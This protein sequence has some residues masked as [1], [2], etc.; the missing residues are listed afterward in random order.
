MNLERMLDEREI[1]QA[2]GRYARALDRRNWALLE[3]VFAADVQADYNGG[4]FLIEGRSA[5]VAMIRS[6]LDGCGPTQ[7]LMGNMTVE[8]NGGRAE[9]RCY[10][11]A[12]HQGMGAKAQLSYEVLG[13]YL[14]QWRRGAEGW[15]ALH[16]TLRVDLE[17]GARE[18]LGPA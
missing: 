12:A 15:R 4:E 17:L 3:T 1:E 6:H 7:H 8:V 16:W 10:V 14:V 13:E 5:L 11:R 9:S 18:V 2:Y